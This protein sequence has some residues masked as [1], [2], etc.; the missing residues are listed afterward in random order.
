[1][2]IQLLKN[3]L[4]LSLNYETYFV[5]LEEYDLHIGDMNQG[6]LLTQNS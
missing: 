4:H 1:M 6:L 5:K 2:E 3:Q